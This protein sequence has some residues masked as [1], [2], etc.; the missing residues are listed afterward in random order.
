[1]IRKLSIHRYLDPGETLGEVLGGFI[2]ALTFTLGARLFTAD[3]SSKR[4]IWSW[5]SSDATSLG[6]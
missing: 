6:G 4:T 2:M 3:G 5:Q 1:M